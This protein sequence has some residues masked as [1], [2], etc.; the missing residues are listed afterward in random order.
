ME[1]PFK[2]QEDLV[3]KGEQMEGVAGLDLDLSICLRRCV[4]SVLEQSLTR[5]LSCRTSSHLP[6]LETCVAQCLWTLR[7]FGL[8]PL[9][10]AECAEALPLYLLHQ[11]KSR[12]VEKLEFG[13]LPS[14]DVVN[15][16]CAFKAVGFFAG[17]VFNG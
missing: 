1:S 17:A 3:E 2:V 16:A 5:Q 13:D 4:H 9:T 8:S 15:E 11:K 6:L 12:D 14:E 10:G 7:P